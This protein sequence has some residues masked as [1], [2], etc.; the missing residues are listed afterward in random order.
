MTAQVTR[1]TGHW[2]GAQAQRFDVGRLLG[3]GGMGVVHEALD[4][5]TGRQIALKTLRDLD[6][7]SRARFKREFR[8]LQGVRHARLVRLHELFEEDGS[9]FFTMDLVNGR[10]LLEAVR[11]SAGLEETKLRHAL[12]QLIDAVEAL[13][14]HGLIHRDIKP[15]NILVTPDGELQLLDFG[16][17]TGE[18]IDK[19]T[20]RHFVGTAA[21]MAPEQAVGEASFETDWY[22]VGVVLFQA[23]TGKLPF[24]GSAVFVITHKVAHDAPR[25]SSLWPEVPPDLDELCAQLLRREPALRLVDRSLLEAARAYVPVPRSRAPRPRVPPPDFVGRGPERA[26]LLARYERMAGGQTVTASVFGESGIGKSALVRRF[27]QDLG[28]QA[29]LVVLT[30]RCYERESIHYKGIDGVVDSLVAFL[31]NL[32]AEDAAYFVPRHVAELIRQFPALGTVQAL[33]RASQGVRSGDLQLARTHGIVALREL[34]V[35][36]CDRYHLVVCI[37]DLQWIDADGEAVLQELMR[38]PES[39]HLLLITTT[40][41]TKDGSAF[42]KRKLGDA[43]Q[44]DL[45]WID[46]LSAEDAAALVDQYVARQSATLSADERAALVA[47]AEGSPMLL[48]EL[49]RHAAGVTYAHGHAAG[50]YNLND[51]I[52]QR[53]AKLPSAARRLLEL[54]C[55]AEMELSRELAQSALGL[56]AGTLSDAVDKLTSQRFLITLGRSHYGPLQPSHDRVRRAVLR[57]LSPEALS[58]LHRELAL[59]LEESGSNDAEALAMDWSR[60]GE[61]QRAAPYAERAAQLAASSFAFD[62]ACALLRLALSGTSDAERRR[63]LY[64][65]LGEAL[66]NAGRG[67]EAARAFAYAADATQSAAEQA[68]L[69][70]RAADQLLRNGHIDGGVEAM[71]AVL[72][73]LGG[74]IATTPRRALMSL[75]Y[76]RGR[77]ALRGLE[78]G[79]RAES[80]I[81]PE[82]LHRVDVYWDVAMGLNLV[83]IIRGVDFQTRCLMLALEAGEPTRLSRCFAVEAVANHS[84]GRK[85]RTRSPALFEQAETLAR[86]SGKRDVWSWLLLSRGI[87]AMQEGRF[88]ASLAASTEAERILLEEC[89]GQYWQLAR[90]QA[91]GVWALA[92][93]GRLRELDQRVELLLR[94]Y[95]ER[96]DLLAQLNMVTGPSHLLGL[97][98]DDVPAMRRECERMLKQ[99]SQRGFHFQHLSALFTLTVGDLYEGAYAQAFERIESRWSDVESSFLLRSEFVRNDSWYLRGRAAITAGLAHLTSRDTCSRIVNQGIRLIEQDD[100]VWS[101]GMAF[102]LRAGLAQALGNTTQAVRELEQAERA[103]RAADMKVHAAACALQNAYLRSVTNA[104]AEG[105][106]RQEG[107]KDPPRFAN[108]LV[109]VRAP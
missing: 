17:V 13:H 23:L 105:T 102:V 20:A 91:F 8:A 6:T 10:D 41:V 56:D 48:F 28:E 64:V 55:V 99:W 14:A 72:A 26:W 3:E 88:E 12:A 81:D 34:L 96:G 73:P 71:R 39:P 101:R 93:L 79:V 4:R 49:L 89:H 76:H 2:L 108:A 30:G 109:P 80:S 22:A 94:D 100:V 18:S 86:A 107:V 54:A 1:P 65:A 31:R 29:G 21:Y 66:C 87:A 50:S 53:A 63:A 59:A 52:E 46:A 78:H 77:L 5:R 25:A 60:A 61:L 32:P 85:G 44:H 90:T 42:S 36:L 97:A 24:D 51:V 9:L 74:G 104:D 45:L 57:G 92:Y 15:S 98:R 27:L 33:T 95:R 69:R 62:R 38:Q 16:L 11:P 40:A 19:S 83:D 35:R 7:D 67:L 47:E 37:D 68:D 58:A 106:L 84:E 75:L 103:F 43:A 82:L 70:R